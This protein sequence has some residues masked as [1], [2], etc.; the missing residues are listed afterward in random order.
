[1]QKGN[2]IWSIN[3]TTCYKN[4]KQFLLWRL[5]WQGLMINGVQLVHK[6]EIYDLWWGIWANIPLVLTLRD[7]SLSIDTLLSAR[8]LPFDS[9]SHEPCPTN[10]YFEAER[11]PR[12]NLIKYTHSDFFGGT[13]TFKLSSPWINDTV[14]KQVKESLLDLNW[15]LNTILNSTTNRSL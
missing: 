10:F 3:A 6:W 8:K 9:S 4:V 14:V 7:I 15:T 5:L 1:M 11:S 13:W 2:Q 12:E